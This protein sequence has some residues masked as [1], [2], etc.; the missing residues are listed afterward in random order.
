MIWNSFIQNFKRIST[1]LVVLVLLSSCRA[2]DNFGFFQP[3]TMNLTVPDGP[4][5]FQAGWHA[6][7][8]SALSNKAFTNAWVYR[9]GN[10]LDMGSGVYQHSS[11]FQT[12]WGQGWFGCYIHNSTFMNAAMGTMTH[13]PLQ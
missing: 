13:G 4:A 1:L 6:G 10:S 11:V 2:R 7:C 3:I 5:E 8:N 12:G 9:K